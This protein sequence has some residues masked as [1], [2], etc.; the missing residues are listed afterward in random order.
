MGEIH[1]E[2]GE[3]GG[4]GV[5]FFLRAV[6]YHQKTLARGGVGSTNILKDHSGEWIVGGSRRNREVGE[7]ARGSRPGVGHNGLE[8]SEKRGKAS[9]RLSV[10]LGG[11]GFAGELDVENEKKRGLGRDSK[12]CVQ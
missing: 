10:F 1:T 3:R 12:A 4:P 5:D 7:V 9:D 11:T 6:R 2:L 8:C